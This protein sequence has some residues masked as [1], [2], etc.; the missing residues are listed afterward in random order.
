MAFLPVGDTSATDPARDVRQR[1]VWTAWRRHYG[2]KPL[3]H[4]TA[5]TLPA[6]SHNRPPPTAAGRGKGGPQAH[7][8]GTRQ[9]PSGDPLLPASSAG[10]GRRRSLTA[11][12]R[13]VD[14]AEQ[15]EVAYSQRRHL[16]V[17]HVGVGQERD[18]QPVPAGGRREVVDLLASQGDL[19]A[20]HQSR[21]WHAERGIA[22]QLLIRVGP[23]P[24]PRPQDAH[25][26][27]VC[28]H[29]ESITANGICA[30]QNQD[31]T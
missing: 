28:G 13:P 21:Q 15:V 30:A 10:C 3:Q 31:P 25:R 8:A 2:G 29:R 17:A 24:T 19:L 9:R 11:V 12:L 26:R 14:P 22:G 23:A 18:C 20:A 27:A 5:L 6:A 16:S 1:R 7:P 4:G